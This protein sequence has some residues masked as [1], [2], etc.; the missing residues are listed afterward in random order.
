MRTG[1]TLPVL[2]A[3]VVKNWT[4]KRRHPF[5]TWSEILN[6]LLCIL[7]FVALKRFEPD[8]IIP[9]GWAT[10]D[11]NESS[12]TYGSTWNL[13]AMTDMESVL[14][15]GLSSAGI[16]VPD[17]SNSASGSNN[18]SGGTF[19]AASLLETLSSSLQ[20]PRFY[21]T[22]TT[23]PG[24]LLSLS[25]QAL[26]EGNNLAE[27]G[28]DGLT[29]CALKFLL[30]G[31]TGAERTTYHVPN[32]CKGRVVPYKIAITPDTPYTREYFAAALE[33]WY[34]RIALAPPVRSIS[35]LTIPSFADSHIFFDNETALET[36]VTSEEYGTEVRHP[37]IYAAIAF[38]EFPHDISTFGDLEGYSIAYSLRFNSTGSAS[39]V[40][41]TKKPRPNTISKF[42]PAEN[43]MKYATRGFMTLQTLVARFLNCMPMWDVQSETTNG[44]CQVD[45]AVMAASAQNDRRLLEQLEKDMIIGTAFTLLNSV[46]DLI[47][48]I[49]SVTLPN[50]SVDTIPPLSVEKLLI[51]LRMAPQSYHGAGVYGTPTQS[52]RYAP[53]FDKIA[54]VFPIGFVLSYLYL[55]SRVIV[56]FLIEKET[57][58]RELMRILGA[59]DTE[60][61]AGWMFAYLPILLLGAMLQTIGAHGLLF[62]NS[63]TTLLFVFFF[64]F[65]TSS[66]SY[67]FM[68]SSLFSRAR[69]GSL[70]GMGLFF[71]MFFLSY[72]FS[73]D[74]SEA[75][76]TCAALLPPISLSQGIGVIA[77]LESFGVGVNHDNTSE[78]VN[79]FR[80]ANAIGMQILDTV[81]YI[82][83]GKYF[84]KVVPQEFGVAE[85]WYFFL[86]KGYWCPQASKLVSAEEIGDLPATNNDTVEAVRQEL[87]TQERNGSAVVISG[88]RKEFSVPGGKKIAVH[89]LDLKL[90]EGQITCLLGHNGAGKTTV[91]SM[92]TG[93]TRP[94]SGNAWVRGHSVVTDMRRI[95]RSLGYCPQHSV[96]YPDLTV[97][98]HLTFYGRLKGFTN[99]TELAAEINKKINEVGLADKTNVLSHALS[100]GMQRKLSLA[101]AFL[102]DSTVVFLDEPTAGM[103]PYSR[104][105]TWEVIQRN[106]AGRV[107]I[108]TTH[109]MDEADI[110]GDRIAI[111]AEGKLQCVGSSLFL[112]KRFGVG[113]R[114]SFVRQSDNGVPSHSIAS[115]IQQHVPQAIIASDIGTELTFQLPFEASAGFPA[116]FREL[117]SRQAELSIVSFAISVTTLEEIFLKVAESGSAE[118]LAKENREDAKM[119]GKVS[120]IVQ[121]REAAMAMKDPVEGDHTDLQH[122]E[123]AS[124]R[125]VRTFSN[126]MKALL[127]K[128][129]QCGRRD[130]NMLFFST[131]LPIAAIFVGLSALKFSVVLLNDPKLELSPTVQY[132]LALQTPVPFGCPGNLD[133]NNGGNTA[134]CSELVEPTYFSEGDTYELEMDTTV[135]SALTT[136][137]VFGV[138]YDSPAIEAN[139]TTGYNLRLAELIFGKGYGYDSDANMTALP[140][141]AG[142]KGQFGGY[143]LHASETTNTLSYNILANGSSTHAAP[144]YKH[145][146]DS[147]IH[148]F[149]LS[150]A[151]SGSK[152]NVTIRVSSHP[153][154]L[155][156]KTRSIFSSYLSFPAVIFIVIAF[157][158]IPASMMPYIVKEKHLEQ[159]AKY[160]QLL[161]GMSFF[162]YWLSNFIFDMALYLVPMVATLLLLRSYGVTKSL[163]S[164]DTCDSCTR[165]VP[166][167]MVTLFVLFGTAIAPWTYLLSHVMEKP[168]ECLLYTVMINFFLGLLLLLLSFTMNSLDSTRPANEVLV[169]IWRCSP[170]FAFGNGFLNVLMADLLALFGLTSSP[171]SAFD[172]DVAGTDIWY[173]LIECPVFLLLAVGIDA[174]KAG[175]VRWRIVQFMDKINT[176]RRM[177]TRVPCTST[178]L[179]IQQKF[180]GD[181]VIASENIDPDVAAEARRVQES[182][183]SLAA[184]SEVVQIF[185]LEK[186]YPN[187]KKA[188]KCLSFGLQQG[189]CYGFLGVNGAGKTTTIKVLT[190]DLLPTSGTAMING[191]DICKERSKA[192]D[193]IGYCPQFDALIDLLTVREHLELFGRFKGFDTN[194]RLKMEVDRLLNKLQIQSFANKLAGSLSGG[195]KRKLSLAIAM[196]G[197]P[198]VL[199]LDEPST[200]V[201]PFSRRLLWDVILEAS[202]KSRK[203]TVMLTTHSME[204]C[205]ALCSKAGIM[206]DGA[207]RCFGSIPHLKNRFGDG[208]MLECK[209]DLP[210]RH[211]YSDL[212]QLVCEHLQT[213]TLNDGIQI[214][215]PQIV[216][217][218]S[219]LG[220]ASYADHAIASFSTQL[221]R[222]NCAVDIASFCN[223]WLL[224]D[225]VQRL[226]KFLHTRFNGVALIERQADFCRYKVTAPRS[227]AIDASTQ[228]QEPIAAVLSRMFEVV[229]AAKGRLGIKEYSLS[230]TTLEQIFNSFAGRREPDNNFNQ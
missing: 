112:K 15:E 52:F 33:T 56:S 3:L 216:G 209:L 114:L 195:N 26:M 86:T 113:Y 131:I 61:F 54:V 27:L 25:L 224:E 217:V 215:A 151:S 65:A 122:S 171:R 7:L 219:A 78:E 53:F 179:H 103:D 170:L 176:A 67:G 107:V 4:V 8:L 116:L 66:F 16:V 22:E 64:T 210:P 142:V 96:L 72:S 74:T 175:T 203:S 75:S 38:E 213:P 70:A 89:G 51:P 98:E 212:V 109:F 88:L 17:D 167:A 100:G 123:F 121:P 159:N 172:A 143:L 12:S 178:R 223:W 111:M 129:V 141:R 83:L 110:L 181:R 91:M 146:I 47:T 108:L 101:I 183:R 40:P 118:V 23:M 138:T 90:Y 144:T 60:L 155:S 50:V 13:Y 99:S 73:D 200:G 19:S 197:D 44:T 45:Q 173:L 180:T 130:F 207:L 28:E 120:I 158:F 126:Q 148:R 204:E 132:S 228:S 189:E 174:V 102:G 205:E 135:Y 104:R 71:I 202:V 117:E 208:F 106:R 211:A 139:D 81:L 136:P 2:R 63:D 97:K 59:K 124:T 77:K 6:P 163:S 165:D 184:N 182:Y 82:L 133:L 199:V 222:G 43:T 161:S 206:V 162:A 177:Y 137:T 48:N 37:K 84:E 79:N 191:F 87:E 41:K 119:D 55:V 157:T 149:L 46:K 185:E 187:G 20:I 201:D 168:S 69:A 169:Y 29:D 95:R 85:K 24:L 156:F 92:L 39:A 36:Y 49:A 32:A 188:V 11:V 154:P 18:S 153:L 105:S 125:A 160:Q 76:R 192:R 230:Q 186:V 229:E 34:P 127:R 226:D 220:N 128:R 140:S 93:M 57:R 30:F 14:N 145:M 166:A 5:A 62:P 152:S 68:I 194:D 193:S 115:L 214:T 58:S 190:G 9:A 42:V 80:F 134:W 1:R 10:S 35:L 221:N 164:G 147:A 218:C 94:S 150:K 31:Y 227:E 21:F 196:I 225:S 198:S